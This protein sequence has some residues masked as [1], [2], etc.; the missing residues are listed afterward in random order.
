M[1]E[2]IQSGEI[3][4]PR[5]LIIR[6]SQSPPLERDDHTER[7]EPPPQV[8]IEKRARFGRLAWL[9]AAIA[10]A[11][12]AIVLRY[13]QPAVT[14]PG[15]QHSAE[16]ESFAQLVGTSLDA[17]VHTA[18]LRAAA[19]ASSSMLRAGIQTDAAT[20]AD[21]AKDQDVV[22]GLAAGERVE[23]FQ[24]GTHAAVSMLRVPGGAAPIPNITVPNIERLDIEGS[25]VIVVVTAPITQPGGATAGLIALAAPID[26]AKPQFAQLSGVALTGFAKPIALGGGAASPTGTT[27]AVPIATTIKGPTL[28][29]TATLAAAPVPAT[30]HFLAYARYACAALATLF[31]LMY[32]ASVI[33]RR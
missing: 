6:S 30:D 28:S 7:T 13:A 5:S 10:P 24:T 3:E 23:V 8:A 19:L 12:A 2:A 22:F 18:Q 17:A 9:I 11:I 21:M 4:L 15:A 16:A 32:L 26:L 14:A 27:I 29:I 1:D 20:L 25:K 33:I 31:L